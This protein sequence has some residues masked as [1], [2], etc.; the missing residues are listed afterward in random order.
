M[1]VGYRGGSK[2]IN[3]SGIAPTSLSTYHTFLSI[4]ELLNTP[5]LAGLL[6]K[7]E[8]YQDPSYQDQVE[9]EALYELLEREIAVRWTSAEMD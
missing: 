4:P 2:C 3:L 9:A 1:D 8:I 6:A 7:G 5:K